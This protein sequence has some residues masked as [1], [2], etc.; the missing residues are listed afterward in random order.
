METR[1]FIEKIEGKKNEAVEASRAKTTIT[2]HNLRVARETVRA[3][4][5]SSK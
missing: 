1:R 3:A 4:N 5:L 2:R